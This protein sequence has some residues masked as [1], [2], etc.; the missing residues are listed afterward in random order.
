MGRFREME[1]FVRVVEAGSF[2]SAA[3]DLKI[4]QPTISYGLLLQLPSRASIWY[5]SL[6][7]FLVC[8]QN[9]SWSL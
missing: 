7:H 4:G 8:I 3:R 5:Q 2:S 1:M 9:Y 6:T